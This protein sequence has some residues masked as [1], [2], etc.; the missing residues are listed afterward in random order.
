[1]PEWVCVMAREAIGAKLRFEILKRDEFRCR[2]CGCSGGDIKLHIDH[3]IPVKAGGPTDKRNLITACADCNMGKAASILGED[4]VAHIYTSK[5]SRK[6]IN[7]CLR[8]LALMRGRGIWY[9]E[10]YETLFIMIE[11]EGVDPEF[12]TTIA[13]RA[14]TAEVFSEC[15]WAFREGER[16]RCEA[17]D[18]EYEEAEGVAA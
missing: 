11:V 14:R 16:L 13:M 8:I 12:I 18:R 7:H 17:E 1:V 5:S 3:V 10:A 4:L 15:V 2:Y 9:K 6:A